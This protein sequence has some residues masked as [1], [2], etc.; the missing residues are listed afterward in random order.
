MALYSTIKA[1]HYLSMLATF[2]LAAAQTVS[3]LHQM[4]K[5]II[6]ENYWQLKVKRLIHL[7]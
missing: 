1:R 2:I 4:S 6:E 3:S 5:K 7:T